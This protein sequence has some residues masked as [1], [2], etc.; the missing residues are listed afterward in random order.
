[1]EAEERT[2]KKTEEEAAAAAAAAAAASSATQQTQEEFTAIEAHLRKVKW[3]G[4]LSESEMKTLIDRAR[5]RVVPRK[6]ICMWHH[7]ASHVCTSVCASARACAS[8]CINGACACAY[9]G[10]CIYGRRTPRSWACKCLCARDPPPPCTLLRV[11]RHALNAMLH[12]AVSY[13][14]THACMWPP[15]P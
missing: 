7:V 1:M 3:F 9:G 12:T 13:T 10:T 2:Q 14:H 4:S 5:H 11:L 15:A 6:C 8:A